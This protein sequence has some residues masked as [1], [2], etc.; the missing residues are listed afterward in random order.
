MKPIEIDWRTN[1]GLDTYVSEPE[2][3]EALSAKA[4]DSINESASADS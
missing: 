2:K 3:T 1:L 4:S